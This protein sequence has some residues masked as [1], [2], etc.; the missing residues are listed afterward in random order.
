MRTV[1]SVKKT[2]VYVVL[3]SVVEPPYNSGGLDDHLRS[4]RFTG[5][6]FITYYLGGIR[7]V[8]SQEHIE[9][10]M[11]ELDELLQRRSVNK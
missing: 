10:T 1:P 2:R 8:V 4:N 5:D 9:I 3:E 11:R 7:T 6:T